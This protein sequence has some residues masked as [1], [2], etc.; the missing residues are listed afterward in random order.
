MEAFRAAGVKCVPTGLD[1]GTITAVFP[2]GP[3]EVTTLR[4]DVATD[5][6]HASVSF[7]AGFAEDAGRRDFTINAMF[8]DKDGKVLDFFGGQA[9]IAARVL[10][11][12]GDAEQRIAEDYLRS[13][14]F[15]RF[16]ARLGFTPDPAALEAIKK[17]SQ[18]LSRVSQER[19]T[20]E[21]KQILAVKEP[22]PV[23]KAMV[24]TG[25]ATAVAPEL[26]FSPVV[27][28]E[29]VGP[30]RWLAML[31]TLALA[32]TARTFDA[33]RLGDRLKLARLETRIL[34]EALCGF[35]C[36]E[37]VPAER[38]L[39]M[40]II[41]AVESAGGE[42]SFLAFFLPTWKA[43]AA[44]PPWKGGPSAA[45]VAAGIAA[46]ARLEAEHGLLRRTKLPITG[47][48]LKRELGLTPG[49]ALGETLERLLKS[50]RNGAWSTRAEGLALERRAAPD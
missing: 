30:Q 26:E 50:F 48:D 2:A 40:E 14:R 17:T 3:V 33:Q 24:D 35:A 42:G 49:P 7:D 25:V 6:R 44:S 31:A 15:F 43:A 20:A 18:G 23:L 32:S 28:P 19:M 46:L 39:A 9:D 8:E 16:W 41:D 27:S 47:E 11:F 45:K 36:L 12:V 38:A 22:Q 21:L 37:G 29:V 34:T 10:R 5:G 13:M 4:R 1:H